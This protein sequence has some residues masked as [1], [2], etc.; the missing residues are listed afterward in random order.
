M[1]KTIAVIL[2]GGSGERMGLEL[3]KQFIK[4]AGKTVIEH[5][6][7][8]FQQ[9]RLIDEICVVVNPA[10]KHIIEEYLLA[11]DWDKVKKILMG[12]KERYHSSLSAIKAY[13]N[14]DDDVSLIFHDAVRPLVSRRII[15]DNIK[16][17][18]EYDAVDTA[19]PSADTII[20][21]NDDKQSIR[22]IPDRSFLRKGQTPQSFKLETIKE[23]YDVA[24]KDPEFKTTDDCGIVREYLSEVDVFVVEGEE[25]NLKL[26]YEEDIYLLDKLFQIKTTRANKSPDTKY[27]EDKVIVVFGGSSGIGAEIASWC[28]NEQIKVFPFSRSLN[29]VDVRNP[30]DI[31]TALKEVYDKERKIDAVINTAAILAKE[32][33]KSMEYE[34][35]RMLT[36]INLSGVFNAALES[37]PYLKKTKGHLL[38]YTSSSYTRGRAMYSIYSATKAAIVNFVQAIAGEWEPYAIQVNCINPERTKTPMRTSNF[39]QEPEET[40]LK[41]EEVAKI[42]LGVLCSELNGQV[43]D[44]KVKGMD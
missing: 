6:V 38:F 34:K 44:I 43:V 15:T 41:A 39:G 20:R 14:D 19:I 23:A 22:N 21:V 30:D 11:N 2:A 4:V 37:L 17:L 33:L 25:Q 10:Y 29:G 24:L 31:R 9:H 3:P 1:S 28:R 12:G 42:S 8:T 7:E 5:T 26:T 16:A 32:P 13:E 27:L 35:I 18:E 36:D 40:L